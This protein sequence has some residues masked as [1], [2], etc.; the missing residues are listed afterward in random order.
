MSENPLKQYFRRPA[1]YMKLPS[2]GK[3]YPEG[4]IDIPPNG[5]IP[6][7][8]MTALDEITSRTPDALFNGSAVVDIIKSCV[9]NIKDPWS[10]TNVDLD[11]LLIAIR[12][13]SMGETMEFETNCPECDEVSKYDINLP[14]LLMN[15]KPMDYDTPLTLGEVIVKFK[16]MN[17]VEINKANL[18]QFEL[19][20]LLE[21]VISSA[22]DEEARAAKSAEAL[23][24][25]NKMTFELVSNT[26]EYIK[27]PG[28]TVFENAFIV[29]FLEN[30]DKLSYSKIRD[31]SVELKQST[32]N[33]PLHIKCT[34]CEHEYEQGFSVNVSD[35]FA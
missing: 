5:E 17:Y 28:A 33:K 22:E 25:I 13:A 9:P 23:K 18:A 30:C 2:G 14:G 21:I 27:I 16:P 15:F 19:Q 10:V 8:P 20:K 6:I 35:F 12:A 31:Y 1:V 32:E 34:H 24:K 7:Y 3:G 29:E 26:I 11:P 4:A